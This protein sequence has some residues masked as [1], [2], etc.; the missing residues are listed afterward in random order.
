MGGGLRSCCWVLKLL[1]L[2]VQPSQ[3]GFDH[4]QP[5]HRLEAQK[6]HLQ[7]PTG[8]SGSL[9]MY[10]LLLTTP[11]KKRQTIENYK[12]GRANQQGILFKRRLHFGG[13]EVGIE[14]KRWTGQT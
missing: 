11:L 7:V 6:N 10:F 12:Q 9:H 2:K 4:T 14:E 3:L 8:D 1:H 13:P 5:T